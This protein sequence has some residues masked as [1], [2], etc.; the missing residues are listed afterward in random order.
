VG[1]QEGFTPRQGGS[2][3]GGEKGG[4]MSFRALAPSKFEKPNEGKC[5]SKEGIR[6]EAAQRGN[7]KSLCFLMAWVQKKRI[8]KT[9]AETLKEKN[10][11]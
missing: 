7:E 1:E 6:G 9:F 3:E 8:G 4:R 2:W 5:G 10:E 11:E